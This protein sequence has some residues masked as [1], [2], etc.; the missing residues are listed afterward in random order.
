MTWA[1]WITGVPGSGKSALARATAET[2]RARGVPVKI[3]ELDALRKILTPHPTYSDH[4]REAV[5]RL[6]AFMAATLAAA[7]VP[8][9]VDATAHRRRWREF[10]R[11]LIPR[12]GEVQL[13]CPLEVAREREAARAAGN[14]PRGIYAHAGSAGA[15]VPGVDRE[16]E[17]ALA[18][19][20][21]IDTRAVGV[22]A[23]ADQIV[24]LA[25]RLGAESPL[26]EPRG[27]G[28]ALWITGRPGSGKTTIARRV[29][30]ALT[31][32]G[33]RVWMVEATAL[34]RIVW[35]V[36][37]ENIEELVHRAVVCLATLLV[38]AGIP[39][40]VDATGHHRRWRDLGRR[41][42][43]RFAEVQLV[44]PPEVC[45]NRERATRWGLTGREG[46]LSAPT[47]GVGIDLILDY[48]PALAPELTIYT[49][50]QDCATAAG[51]VLFVAERLHRPAVIHEGG[52]RHA[53][54]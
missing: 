50:V 2:L 26:A 6:L 22:A 42:I 51:D 29:M 1:I 31:A 3:L 7:G 13:E 53:S 10:A 48:E 39:V 23:G 21:T 8:V 24:A 25:K 47:V 9:I 49:D 17:R 4:E 19:E 52:D 33:I 34:R 36:A 41:L 40:I 43:P 45:A 46:V 14:A 11:E 35:P 27:A 37:V 38:E 20:L 30:E 44:C 18:P 32:R 5:Y 16:Y 12:F 28:W 54:E 15:T